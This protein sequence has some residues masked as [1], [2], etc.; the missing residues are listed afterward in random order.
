M[1]GD[2][3]V[4]V[5]NE[6]PPGRQK[7]DT[8][9]VNSSFRDRIYKFTEKL[10]GEGGQAFIVCPLVGEDDDG[11]GDEN[12]NNG[13]NDINI[14]INE[15]MEIHEIPTSSNNLSGMKSV[16]SYFKDLSENIFPDIP[17]TFIHGK[18]KSEDK[19][20]IME[21]FKN[22]DIK[23]LVSTVVIEVGVNIPNAVLMVI[24]NAE[25][26]GLSQLH[27]LRGR[28]GR[29]EKKSY[30]ILFSDNESETSKKR[31]DIMCKTNDGFEIAKKDIE[32]RG[33]G[34]LFGEKQSGA[35]TFKIADLAADTEI[36][37]SAAK[38]AKETVAENK[39]LFDEKI[40]SNRLKEAVLKMFNSDE[41]RKIA[42]N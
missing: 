16:K 33:P 27:Q 30:C 35:V 14:N 11:D 13:E 17:T 23:I 5:V 7:V 41:Q 2:L 40:G 36:L 34:D 22:G 26:F 20:A 31:L 18:M 1:Y 9:A 29:G 21:Q 38:A 6:L 37:Y 3:D 4:S 32:I 25:R 15:N 28:V 12:D 39:D 19:D 42:F 8:F 10:I 24:E